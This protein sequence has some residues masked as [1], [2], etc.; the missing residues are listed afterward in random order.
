MAVRV[1]KWTRIGRPRSYNILTVNGAFMVSAGAQM[2]GLNFP[3]IV[4]VPVFLL[5]TKWSGVKS[6]ASAVSTAARVKEK[7]GERE[8][9]RV[10]FY[11]PRAGMA[12]A[13]PSCGRKPIKPGLSCS[14]DVPKMKLL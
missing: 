7:G 13:V 6:A 4:H 2:Y 14:G 1:T 3:S 12:A 8:Q 10:P 5:V 11:S 9:R